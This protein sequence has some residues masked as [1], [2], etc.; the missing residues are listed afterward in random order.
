MVA[1]EAVAVPLLE[2][3]AVVWL[4]DSSQISLPEELA[5][6]W[7][8]TGKQHTPQVPAGLK[9]HTALDRRSGQVWGPPLSDGRSAD[10][11]SPLREIRLPAGSLRLRDR[12][13]WR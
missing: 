9:L 5:Q 6:R 8:A 12:G 13:D 4:E 1:S 11:Q 3:F 10:T 2:R 7:Q